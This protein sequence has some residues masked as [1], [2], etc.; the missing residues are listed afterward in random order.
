[1]TPTSDPSNRKFHLSDIMLVYYVE[2]GLKNNGDNQTDALGSGD[3][4]R[5]RYMYQPSEHNIIIFVCRDLFVLNFPLK[6][7]LVST[8]RA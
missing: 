3:Y 1:M 7:T 6:T 4:L 5:G 8:I 2:R